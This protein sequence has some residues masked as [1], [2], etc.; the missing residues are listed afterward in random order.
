M[1]IMTEHAAPVT[2]TT[3]LKEISMRFLLA[4]TMMV[5]SSVTC[6]AADLGLIDASTLKSH[7]AKWVILDARPK[8]D[9]EAGHI[10]GAIQFF[11]DSYTRTDALGVKYSS[12]PPSELALALASG[13]WSVL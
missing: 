3:S 6:F 10:P 2:V 11:W 12:F 7:S 1:Q 4:A 9:W 13:S 5:L 8:A